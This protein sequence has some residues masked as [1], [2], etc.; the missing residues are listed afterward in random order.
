MKRRR[1]NELLAVQHEISADISDS[2]VGTRQ[3]VFVQGVSE[4]EK[5][6]A[7]AA[8]NGMVSLT[9][10]GRASS[11]GETNSAVIERASGPVQ[12]TGRTDG[13]LI[14]VFDCPEGRSPA[15]LIGRIVP[16]RVTGANVLT[17]FGELV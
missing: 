12:M 17:L 13:D 7:R 14:V 1:C 15:E 4:Y 5:K 8:D 9:V 3:D 2:V 11:G 16:V 6:R 10:G